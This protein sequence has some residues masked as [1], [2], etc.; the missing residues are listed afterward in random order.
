M[1]NIILFGAPGTGKGTQSK[2]IILKY[3]LVHLSTGDIIR[4]EISKCSPVGLIAKTYID[5]GLL[6]PDSIIIKQ[7]FYRASRFEKPNGFIFDG[8]PRTLNQAEILDKTLNKKGYPVSMVFYLDV[9]EEELF[10]R[11]MCRSLHSNRADDNEKIIHKRIEVYYKETQPIIKFYEKQN[12]L[13]T[14]KGMDS[15]DIV[16]GLI[17]EEIDKYIDKNNLLLY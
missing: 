6:V 8:F 9:S 2:N 1:L 7:L 4:E 17:S 16:S 14:I 5:Q 12:K 13:I 15:V 11:I 10:K 3:H